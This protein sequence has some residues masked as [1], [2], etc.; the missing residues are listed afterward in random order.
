[1]A[2]DDHEGHFH[3]VPAMNDASDF[4]T[5]AWEESRLHEAI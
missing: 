4:G 5:G 1:M 2:R 3:Q